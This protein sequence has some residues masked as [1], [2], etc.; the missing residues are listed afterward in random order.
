MKEESLIKDMEK[1][2]DTIIKSLSTKEEWHRG[3]SIAYGG[4]HFLTLINPS[5]SHEE[6]SKKTGMKREAVRKWRRRNYPD[7]IY[8]QYFKTNKHYT[9]NE[10]TDLKNNKEIDRSN[11]SK[12]YIKRK[13]G[14]NDN[15]KRFY[16]SELRTEEI[17]KLAYNKKKFYTKKELDFILESDL[18][19]KEVAI[20][21]GRTQNAIWCIRNKYKK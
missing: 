11:N 21:L 19:S 4:E 6:A 16:R 3:N 9:T 18:N 20:Q 2:L 14:L 12:A 13:L 15:R 17:S 7:S 5:I 1:I 10:I 8:K